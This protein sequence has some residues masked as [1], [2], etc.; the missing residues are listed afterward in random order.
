MGRQEE[1]RGR[2]RVPL[3][4]PPN[5][6]ASGRRSGPAPPRR[7]PPPTLRLV[8]RAFAS[9]WRHPSPGPT[10][11]ALCIAVPG[12]C[13]GDQSPTAPDVGRDLPPPPPPPP[14]GLGLRGLEIGDLASRE[15]R[16]IGF[17]RH[18]PRAREVRFGGAWSAYPLLPSG[19]VIVSHIANGLFVLSL[20]QPG[21]ACR[22]GCLPGTRIA[23]RAFVMR[24]FLLLAASLSLAPPA[25]AQD[26]PRTARVLEVT[27]AD[28]DEDSLDFLIGWERW[29][30]DVLDVASESG[31]RYALVPLLPGMALNRLFFPAL[32]EGS[33][34]LAAPR[35]SRA[36]RTRSRPPVRIARAPRGR[37][38][39]RT[40][41][42]SRTGDRGRPR[43]RGLAPLGQ[44]GTFR[45][46]PGGTRG[47]GSTPARGP[48]ARIAPPRRTGSRGGA[49][50]SPG[51]APGGKARPRGS[52]PRPRGASGARNVGDRNPRRHR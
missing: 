12:V 22:A 51:R 2:A 28:L 11:A 41:D 36:A 15:L 35:T 31:S 3:S 32:L 45:P 25:P 48:G 1:A 37:P 49:G 7:P 24:G 50:A 43:P 6:P 47:V 33:G 27:L 30:G 40:G 21:G 44:P 4:R 9:L 46:P 39:G 14:L 20:P 13:G 10:R 23:C 5:D 16:E 26:E 29:K 34:Q 17:L 8:F 42:G 18:V 52:G 38:S 19:T